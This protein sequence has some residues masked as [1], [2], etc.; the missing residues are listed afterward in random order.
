MRYM[1]DLITYAEEHYGDKIDAYMVCGGSTYE[2]LDWLHGY[3]TVDKDKAWAEWQ[4]KH[5]VQYEA[6][7]PSLTARE[8]ISS[9]A[10]L[11]AV[12]SSSSYEPL[13]PPMMLRMLAAK[14]LMKLT[15]EMTSPNTT[16]LYSLMLRPSMDGVVVTI[17]VFYL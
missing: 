7:A 6:S 5:G 9:M 15:P 12:I 16:P 4:K 2:W 14:S 11:R 13:R 17:I 10:W 8:H 1:K 3:T